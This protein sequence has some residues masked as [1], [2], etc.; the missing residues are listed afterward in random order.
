MHIL[1]VRHYTAFCIER[2]KILLLLSDDHRTSAVS[3]ARSPLYPTNHRVTIQW[4]TSVHQLFRRL[5]PSLM[6]VSARDSSVRVLST[7]F[8][9]CRHRV[10]ALSTTKLLASALLLVSLSAISL[11][12]FRPDAF[13]LFVLRYYGP[14]LFFKNDRMADVCDGL[15]AFALVS[16]SLS[17][18]QTA[19]PPSGLVRA[20]LT[21][22]FVRPLLQFEGLRTPRLLHLH[23]RELK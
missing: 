15:R 6:F 5:Y 20:E 13:C 4:G 17:N 7:T 3:S 23:Y 21:K 12:G 22:T 2:M 1:S 18:F 14:E 11:K 9:S 19:R 16:I 10:S 8:D